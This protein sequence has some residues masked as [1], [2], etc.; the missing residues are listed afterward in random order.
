M[1]EIRTLLQALLQEREGREAAYRAW[2]RNIQERIGAIQPHVEERPWRGSLPRFAGRSGN[3]VGF[4]ATAE[5]QFR[6]HGPYSGQRKI[7]IAVSYFDGPAQFWWQARM[8]EMAEPYGGDWNAFS[9]ACMAEFFNN[10]GA[11]TAQAQLFKLKQGRLTVELYEQRFEELVSRSGNTL[12]D[13]DKATLF[14]YGL[15]PELQ[16]AVLRS[17][18]PGAPLRDLV[19]RAVQLEGSGN[20]GVPNLGMPIGQL[21]QSWGDVGDPMDLGVA[22]ATRA[23]ERRARSGNRSGFRGRCFACQQMGH[24]AAQCPTRRQGVNQIVVEEPAENE[25][26]Q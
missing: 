13:K 8:A 10:V 26:Q 2:E 18:A 5:G 22:R 14:V 16:D 4:L 7:D 11:L 17:T 15:R 6:V 20:T 25:S 12:V 21:P 9:A 1:E 24:V 23:G 3:I 19:V